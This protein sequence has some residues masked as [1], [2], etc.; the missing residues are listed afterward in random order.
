MIAT[1]DENNARSVGAKVARHC[2]FDIV[3]IW[4]ASSHALQQDFSTKTDET[5][6]ILDVG[7]CFTLTQMPQ[8]AK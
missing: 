4:S 2:M 7:S 5:Q 8:K 6:E 3:T 1:H